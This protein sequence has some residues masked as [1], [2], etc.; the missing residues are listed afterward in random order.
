MKL[1][2]NYPPKSG[3]EDDK[4]SSFKKAG[5]FVRNAGLATIATLAMSEAAS[6]KTIETADADNKNSISVATANE[7]SL[8]DKENTVDFYKEKRDSMGVLRVND[9]IELPSS[10]EQTKKYMLVHFESFD[11]YQQVIDYLKKQGYDMVSSEEM[12]KV[13]E[14]N[15]AKIPR[16][17]TLVA[18]LPYTN[19]KI[20]I[21]AQGVGG[22]K[23]DTG[24]KDSKNNILYGGS[25][26][27]TQESILQYVFVVSKT[28]SPA[29]D[30][31]SK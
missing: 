30:I 15:K 13:L 25:T 7:S 26:E 2:F 29:S 14:N 18:T 22:V 1:N 27:P 24:I 11:S 17:A 12:H 20:D 3:K 31:A 21:K 28:G 6:A 9:T 4:D 19:S 16:G 10:L 5:K 8:M 23:F